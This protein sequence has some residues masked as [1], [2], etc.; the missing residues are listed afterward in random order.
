MTT[1][2]PTEKQEA[3]AQ[4]ILI[5]DNASDAYRA[6]YDTGDMNLASIS[7]EAARLLT[8]PTVTTRIAELKASREEKSGID[9]AWLLK[10]LAEEATADAADLYDENGNIK[11]IHEWPMIWR[12]GLVAGIDTL[13]E[14]E[15]IDGKKEAMGTVTKIKVSD[16]IKRL[17][18]IGKHVDVQAF[19]ERTKSTV[20]HT[21]PGLMQ[22]L[23]GDKPTE[24]GDET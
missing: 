13:Q 15:T 18:L 8:N 2:E 6:A 9:A 7:R 11:S 23:Y 20:A 3:F 1:K 21:F 12:T 24:N 17:D 22:E 4:A 10:R 16:R 19:L 5:E 14:Y